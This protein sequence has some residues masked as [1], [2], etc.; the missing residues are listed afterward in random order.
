MIGARKTNWFVV[1]VSTVVALILLVLG[2]VVVHLNNEAA[3]VDAVPSGTRVDVE[4]GAISYGNGAHTVDTYVDFMCPACNAFEQSFSERLDSLSDGDKVTWNVHP[5][6]ALDRFS[7]G[8]EY[9]SRAASAV[10]CVAEDDP[11]LVLDFIG[12][13]FLN[14]PAEN[15]AGLTSDQLADYAR[16]VGAESAMSCVRDDVYAEYVRVQAEEHDIRSTPTIEL[17]GKRVESGSIPELFK[18]VDAFLANLP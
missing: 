17:D 18:K 13:L 12:L 8:T 6:S 1:G 10:Y 5:I 7:Q 2:A 11:D 16:A 4:T 3:T 14:Q 15:T 9:S